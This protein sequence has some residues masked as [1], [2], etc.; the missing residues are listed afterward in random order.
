[1]L[2]SLLLLVLLVSAPPLVLSQIA[3]GHRSMHAAGDAYNQNDA[4][5]FESLDPRHDSLSDGT[6]GDMQAQGFSRWIRLPPALADNGRTHRAQN[7][8]NLRN[9][10]GTTLASDADTVTISNNLSTGVSGGRLSS[11]V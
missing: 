11:V 8:L 10:T 1:M 4:A 5:A 3:P 7:Y 9:G 2:K 6:P